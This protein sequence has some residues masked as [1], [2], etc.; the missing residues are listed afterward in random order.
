MPERQASR[1]RATALIV[2]SSLGF[3]SLSTITLLA[4]HEGLSL[5]PAMLWRYLLAVVVLAAFIRKSAGMIDSR[6]ALQLMIIGGVGQALITYLSLKALDYLPVGPL[7]FLFYT[8]PAWVAVISAVAGKEKLTVARVVALGV[9]MI[10]IAVMVGTPGKEHLNKTGVSLALGIAFIY[11]LYLPALHRV[12]SGIRPEIATLYL[13][14]GV[15]VS[16]LV[17]A[18][19][20]GNAVVPRSFEQWKYVV[21]LAIICTVLAFSTLISGLRVLGPVS[22]S[23]ISTIEPF[24]TAMLGVLVLGQPLVRVT[25]AGGALV[26]VAV[27]ILQLAGAAPESDAARF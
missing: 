9:A 10:G 25:L 5:L 6:R 22:T 24:F 12:Q 11:A 3:G 17:T 4:E 21:L 19:V 7:A 23:I 15:M 20:T 16:F 14:A 2:V 8:Y 13:L 27:V 26:A 18:I 1:T